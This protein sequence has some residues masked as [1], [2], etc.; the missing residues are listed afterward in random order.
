MTGEILLLVTI[1]VFLFLRCVHLWNVFNLPLL[2]NGLM[3]Q[4]HLCPSCACP[5]RVLKPPHGMGCTLHK[6]L[7]ASAL[8]LDKAPSS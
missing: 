2:E 7:L 8:G 1:R 4:F 5:K 6:Y 3:H